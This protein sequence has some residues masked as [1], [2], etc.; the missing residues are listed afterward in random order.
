MISERRLVA[1]QARA[2]EADRKGYGE[3]NLRVEDVHAMVAAIRELRRKDT[4]YEELKYSLM[5]VGE[6][7]RGEL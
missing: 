1:A 6:A 2:N 4:K 3:V 7:L 5:Q